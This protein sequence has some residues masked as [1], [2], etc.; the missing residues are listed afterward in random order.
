MNICS[1]EPFIGWHILVCN[2][3]INAV[4]YYQ[5]RLTL[6]YCAKAKYLKKYCLALETF[7]SLGTQ[8]LRICIILEPVLESTKIYKIMKN[9]CLYSRNARKFN[10][11]IAFCLE[12]CEL[13]ARKNNTKLLFAL[14]LITNEY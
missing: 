13:T 3:M 7:T 5:P 14:L 2:V 8:F 12:S 10:L 4:N 11:L 9:L 1:V 6:I